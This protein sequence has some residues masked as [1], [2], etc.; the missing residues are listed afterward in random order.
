MPR[1]PI[2]SGNYKPTAT[3]GAKRS[4]NGFLRDALFALIESQRD[5]MEQLAESMNLASFA[6][7]AVPAAERFGML[8]L[9]AR[10]LSHAVDRGLDPE[11]PLLDLA[12]TCVAWLEALAIAKSA[13]DEL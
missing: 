10:T 6:D 12:A 5:D 11:Q 1:L 4:K 9:H 8:Q 7:P 2:P 3:E 13:G